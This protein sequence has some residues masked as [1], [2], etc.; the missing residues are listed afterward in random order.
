M[1]INS[2]SSSFSAYSPITRQPQKQAAENSDSSKAAKTAESNTKG[3]VIELSDVP[4]VI[5]MKTVEQWAAELDNEDAKF[6]EAPLLKMNGALHKIVPMLNEINSEVS[7]INKD[8]KP[9]DWD[10]VLKDGAV[11]VTG[12]SLSEKDKNSIE[13]TL[14]SNKNFVNYVKDVYDSAEAYYQNAPEHTS[15]FSVGVLT[16]ENATFFNHVKDDINGTLAI[17]GLLA[18]SKAESTEQYDAA[19]QMHRYDYVMK[20]VKGHLTA[21]HDAVYE[22]SSEA[23]VMYKKG[24]GV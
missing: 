9:S 22:Y 11:K 5:T 3:T 23:G 13:K 8:I 1:A 16:N 14:N 4:G 24:K 18:H 2:I 17:K 20:H 12:A 10:F 7:S 19:S 6:S 21:S 15:S